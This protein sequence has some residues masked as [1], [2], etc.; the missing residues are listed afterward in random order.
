MAEPSMDHLV[1]D[2]AAVTTARSSRAANDTT[3]GEA[4]PLPRSHPSR[5]FA[6]AT[7]FG[8]EPVP[9]DRCRVLELGEANV[10]EVDGSLGQFDYVVCHGVPA[11][12]HDWIFGILAERLSPAGVAYVSYD[13]Y[14]G[15]GGAPRGAPSYFVEVVEKAR[16][17]GL[18]YLADARLSTMAASDLRPE[19]EERVRVLGTDRIHVEQYLD[20]VRHRVFRESL[21]VRHAARSSPDVDPARVQAL[22]VASRGEPASAGA[23][24]HPRILQ[25]ALHLLGEAYPG[26]LAYGELPALARALIG[27]APAGPRQAFEDT[28]VLAHEL[29]RCAMSADHVELHGRPLRR[30]RRAG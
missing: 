20:L 5:L 17:H 7:L 4:L 8:A 22:H 3:P 30:A 27:G 14:P 29:L 24:T 11:E 10:T 21:F 9:L 13:T 18:K 16:A 6:T 28:T 2:A 12:V 1:L 19:I 15:R 23:T 25:A 26:T